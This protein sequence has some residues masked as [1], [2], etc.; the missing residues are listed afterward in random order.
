MGRQEQA[1]SF[2]FVHRVRRCGGIRHHRLRISLPLQYSYFIPN[3]PNDTV[4]SLAAYY[5][6]PTKSGLTPILIVYS[7][8]RTL[9]LPLLVLLFSLFVTAVSISNTHLSSISTMKAN[10]QFDLI[11][12]GATG[13]TGQLAVEYLHKQYPNL[14][15]AL[16][17]R[18]RDKLAQVRT[19]ICGAN[20]QVPLIVADAVQHFEKLEEMA[21]STKV[22]A[23]YAGTPFIDKGLPLVEACA[24][25]GTCYI[26]ITGEV[27]FQRLSYDRYHQKALESGALIVH[28]CGYDSVPSDLG[29]MLVADAMKERHGCTCVSIE[30]VGGK[31]R[32]GLSGGTLYTALKLIFDKDTPG[33]AECKARGSY[34]LD[35]EGAM[36]GPDTSDSVSFVSFDEVSRRYVVPFIMAGANAPVVRK[37]NALLD[38][39]YGRN[40][41][42]RE[43]QAV[44]NW[45]AGFAGLVGF[46]IFGALLFIP[47]TRWL[48]LKVLPKPGEGPSKEVQEKGFFVSH[49][50]AVG[51]TK[52]KPVVEGYV[53]SGAAGDP[54]YKATAR[55][56]IESALCMALER[57]SC[58]KGG[59]LTPAT[60]LGTTLVNRLNNI[61]MELG[62]V[63]AM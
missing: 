15:Y 60:A 22:I 48:L 40:C 31:S 55:M 30:L 21:A 33:M 63:E 18:N 35:P 38:Y 61:G 12:Y 20:S 59:I 5:S 53:K 34:P 6:M 27:P 54:G 23:N 62:V 4:N 49:F 14:K 39:R 42:Y 29:A 50:Y 19:Q 13:F 46:G 16:A 26:D 8:S 37:S 28:A 2:L 32:G 10:R 7:K 3:A 56:S 47:P 17:G 44:P 45:I 24:K 1:R 57:D 41:S 11:I 52:D 25:Q 36:G 9:L 58:A 51:D 43:V